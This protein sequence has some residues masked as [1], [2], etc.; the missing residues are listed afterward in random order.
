[1]SRDSGSYRPDPPYGVE[2][3]RLYQYA[4]LMWAPSPGAIGQSEVAL[5]LVRIYGIPGLPPTKKPV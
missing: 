3:L 5:F 1:M 4:G 2:M